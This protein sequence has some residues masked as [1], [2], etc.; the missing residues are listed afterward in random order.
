ME[1]THAGYIAALGRAPLAVET[2]R[3]Y[4]SKVRGYLAWLADTA[5]DG[6][7][8]SD[9]AARD[10]AVR[11]YRT[12]LAAVLKRSN[13]TTPWPPSTTST[14]APVSAPPPPNASTYPPS[15]REP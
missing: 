7:P 3:T 10:W 11:D 1:A 13:A 12:H 4:A 14:P 9:P 15:P 8:L 6:D 5:V 2:R